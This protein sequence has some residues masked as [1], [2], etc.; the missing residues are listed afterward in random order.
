MTEQT[1]EQNNNTEQQ[2]QEGKQPAS[3]TGAKL[4][5]LLTDLDDDRRQVILG[6][7]NKARSEAAKYRKE[8]QD[9]RPAAQELA[10]LKQQGLSAEQRLADLQAQLLEGELQLMRNQVAIDKGLP[11]ALAVCLDGE[12]EEEMIAVAD[13][14]IAWRDATSKVAQVADLKQGTRGTAPA[15]DPNGWLREMARQK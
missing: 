1:L 3:A 4:E 2:P 11:P 5:D 7:V 15:T 12:T 14:L 6:Q 9:L 10:D 8:A 13:A